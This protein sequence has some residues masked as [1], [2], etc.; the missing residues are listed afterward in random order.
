MRKLVLNELLMISYQSRK[1]RRIGFHPKTTILKGEN[2]VG[3][4]SVLK[5]IYSTFG[6]DPL[7]SHSSWRKSAVVS[8]VKFSLDGIRYSILRRGRSFD[9]FDSDNRLIESFDSITDGLSAFYADFF[10]FKIKLKDNE[11]R[12]VTPPPQYL[13]L[14]F[15]I[16]QDSSWKKNWYS[17]GKLNYLYNWRMSIA[18]YH[19]GVK[20]NEY[21]EIKGQIDQLREAAKELEN[22]R[23]TLS[24]I[25]KKSSERFGHADFDIDMEAFKKEV[26]ELVQSCEELKKMEGAYKH[27]LTVLHNSKLRL[28]NEVEIVEKTHKE[29]QNDYLYATD[30]LLEDHINCPTCGAAYENSFAERFEIAKDRDRCVELLLQLNKEL[31]ELNSTISKETKKY[32]TNNR[33]IQKIEVLLQSRKGNVQLR[34]LIKNEGKKEFKSIVKNDITEKMVDIRNIEVSIERL[35]KKLESHKDKE[36]RA[37]IIS[38]YL[39]YM[40]A[41]LKYLGVNRLDEE[42]YRFLASNIYETGSELPRALLAYY[43]SVLHIMRDYSSSTFFPIVIDSPH[44]QDLDDNNRKV[45][46]KFL[47]EYQPRDSQ[48]ILG[49]VDT[50]GVEFDGE[51]IKL[52]DKYSVLNEAQYVDVKGEMEIFLNAGMFKW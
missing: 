34:D 31:A 27:K 42:T 32:D 14:P 25:L 41:F 3:K 43:F 30:A 52:E 17:F 23:K 22:D 49:L 5:S 38:K 47:K 35:N 46:V 15:Y 11:S 26:D 44:Q 2:S 6:A 10:D 18:E 4:S 48:L 28:E 8:L 39:R 21:Y 40:K 37:E 7:V 20:T 12:L 24:N 50:C 45:L 13:F 36:R 9:I 19:M 16:D 29:L 51:V 33:E 1:A